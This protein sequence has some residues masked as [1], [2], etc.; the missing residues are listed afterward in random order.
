MV[1]SGYDLLIF[2]IWKEIKD[3]SGEDQLKRTCK[4]SKWALESRVW[5]KSRGNVRQRQHG[6]DLKQRDCKEVVLSVIPN[7]PRPSGYF[8]SFGL[9]S[10]AV[11][12]TW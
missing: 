10:K 5:G 6:R 9:I 2:F 3:L 1:G 8:Y 7:C 12:R 11:G 4:Q